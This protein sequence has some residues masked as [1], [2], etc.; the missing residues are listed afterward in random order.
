LPEA[1]APH[2]TPQIKGIQVTGFISCNRIFQ[3]L[4]VPLAPFM[5]SSCRAPAPLLAVG[6]GESLTESDEFRRR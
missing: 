5:P 2:S 1:A 4:L 6:L 3:M